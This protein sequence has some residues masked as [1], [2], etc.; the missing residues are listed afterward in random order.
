MSPLNLVLNVI[1]LVFAGFWLAVGYA[2]AGIVCWG[3]FTW[4]GPAVR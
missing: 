4:A 1:W 2:V 3:P